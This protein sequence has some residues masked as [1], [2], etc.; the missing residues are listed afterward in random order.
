MI[1]RMLIF[2]KPPACDPD[3]VARGIDDILD[4]KRNNAHEFTMAITAQRYIDFLK[5]LKREGVI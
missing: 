1:I 4:R 2:K 3:L 5:T